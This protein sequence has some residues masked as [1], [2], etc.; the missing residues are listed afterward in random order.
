MGAQVEQ[1]HLEYLRDDLEQTGQLLRQYQII[2]L[3][4]EIKNPGMD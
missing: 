3:E 2:Q 1:T 4:G